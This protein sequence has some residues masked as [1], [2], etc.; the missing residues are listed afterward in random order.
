M[1]NTP[2]FPTKRSSR[3][4]EESKAANKFCEGVGF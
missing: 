1:K 2:G 4:I 3:A